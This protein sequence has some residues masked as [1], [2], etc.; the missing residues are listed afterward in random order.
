[1]SLTSATTQYIAHVHALPYGGN[2]NDDVTIEH[3][4]KTHLRLV[5]SIAR[6]KYINSDYFEDILQEG[7]LALLKAAEKFDPSLGFSFYSLA[8]P[9]VTNAMMN[10]YM[11]LNSQ[12][13]MFTT[14]SLRKAYFNIDNYRV[15]KGPLTSENAIKMAEELSISIEDVHECE[16]RLSV[17]LISETT[18]SED[19][20]D[21]DEYSSSLI[22]LSDLSNEPTNILEMLEDHDLVTNKFREAMSSLK[23]RN[24]EIVTARFLQEVPETLDSLGKKYGISGQRVDQ[25]ASQSMKKIREKLKDYA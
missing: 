18:G 14:H 20:D 24:Q 22:G 25:I 12:I 8:K 6:Q 1:M 19:I 3:L 21:G 4:V 2:I 10:A 11:K 15:N 16:R 7:S 23:P 5:V 13:S 9:I 17:S